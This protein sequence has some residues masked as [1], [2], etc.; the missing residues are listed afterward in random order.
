MEIKADS[1]TVADHQRL[2]KWLDD[3]AL[4]IF[5][6]VLQSRQLEREADASKK[7]MIGTSAAKTEAEAVFADAKSIQKTIELILQLREQ[8]QFQ[9][10]TAT[11]NTTKP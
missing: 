3:T 10:F 5:V 9:K 7:W 11:P 6:T 1:L 8:K 2:R 4:D